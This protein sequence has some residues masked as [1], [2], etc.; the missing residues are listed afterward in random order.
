[1]SLEPEDTGPL[2]NDDG[3]FVKGQSGN[4]GGRP[5]GARSKFGEAFVLD[6]AEDWEV[7]GKGAL[8]KLREES[9]ENY[10]RV[11]CTILPKVIELDDDT[12]EILAKAV[13]AHIDF[14]K[15]RE[16]LDK[17]EKPDKEKK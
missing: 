13:G 4:P 2:R 6:F 1:M 3:T 14:N 7:N 8:K 12:K 10:V 11:G 17:E 5:K 16:K 9:I 15:I